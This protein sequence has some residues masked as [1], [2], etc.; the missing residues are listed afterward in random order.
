M[1][2]LS[3]ADIIDCI[4]SKADGKL[5]IRWGITE[6]PTKEGNCLKAVKMQKKKFTSLKT[7]EKYT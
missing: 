3:K 5:V 2:L 1:K 4:H 6:F 7:N